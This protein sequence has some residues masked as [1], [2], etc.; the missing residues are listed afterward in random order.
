M[1]L[2]FSFQFAEVKRRPQ[3]FENTVASSSKLPTT[4]STFS[5]VYVPVYKHHRSHPRTLTV[6]VQADDPTRGF[7][8]FNLPNYRLPNNRFMMVDFSRRNPSSEKR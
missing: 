8:H 1:N 4:S 6:F 3:V 5:R 7:I 2:P